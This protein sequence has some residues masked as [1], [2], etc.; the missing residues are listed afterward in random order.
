MGFM[1]TI[2]GTAALAC[3]LATGL[4]GPTWAEDDNKPAAA[5]GWNAE[6]APAGASLTLDAKQTELVKQVNGYFNGLAN[7]KGSFVQTGGMEKKPQRGKFFVKRPGKFR[8][9]YALPSKQLVVSDGENLAIQDHDIDKEDRASLDQTPFRLLLRQDVDLIRDAK[10]TEVQDS[11]DRLVIGLQD[12]SPD[13]PGHIKLFFSKKPALELKEWS[14]V[15]AQNLET[16]VEVSELVKTEEIDVGLF[17]IPG[18]GLMKQN[19]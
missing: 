17:K 5:T 15:D 16:R 13:T 19:P 8:F 12:K 2:W 10:I 18:I 4:A 14:T 7:L 3:V 11:D 1:K 6:V 9:E